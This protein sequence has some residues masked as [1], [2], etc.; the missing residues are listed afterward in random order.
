MD[1]AILQLSATDTKADFK[2]SGSH[3]LLLKSKG[4]TWVLSIETP[5]GG[6]IKVADLTG[7][8]Q[9]RVEVPPG[10]MLTLTGGTLGAKAW[11]GQIQRTGGDFL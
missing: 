3:L 5:D 9:Q 7:D 4:G 2:L 6:A 10:T 1:N 8:A 11:T